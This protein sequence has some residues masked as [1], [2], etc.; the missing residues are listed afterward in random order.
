MLKLL[1][2]VAIM[3]AFAL[4][5]SAQAPAPSTPRATPVPAATPAT[6][7]ARGKAAGVEHADINSATEKQLEA[8]H[9]VGPARA[10]AIIAGHPYADLQDLVTKKVLTQDVF[11]SAKDRMALANVNTASAAD[12]QRTLPGVGEVRSKAI[13]TGRPYAKPEDMVTKGVL[14]Q[15]MFDKI[16]GLV[17]S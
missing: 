14:T 5:A 7:P 11:D 10:K 2:L 13:V 17:V 9:G 15:E 1:R 16:K 3:A 12:M 6:T 8:L 4:P